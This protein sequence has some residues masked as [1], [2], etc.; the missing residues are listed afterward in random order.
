[1]LKKLLASLLVV[2]ATALPAAAG[3]D[4]GSV[5]PSTKLAA[6]EATKTV[7]PTDDVVFAHKSAALDDVAVQQLR[8]VARW[9]R[10][11]PGMLVLEGH[12]NSLGAPAYN[13]DLSMRRA[14]I[15]RQHLMG[16]GI[17]SDRIMLV[18]YG[19]SGAEAKPSPLDRRVVMYATKKSP[20]A[21]VRA[22]LDR[23]DALSAVWTRKGVL[24]T[25]THGASIVA[26]R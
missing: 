17:S 19:E 22:R 23:G 6:S 21:I 5:T 20:K 26:T 16:Y 9:M 4:F 11:N 15:V 14:E 1:M 8:T 2:G 13:D 3:A 18:V 7:L 24:F 25:E 12:A 10:H